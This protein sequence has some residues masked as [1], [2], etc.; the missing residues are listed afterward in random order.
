MKI[1]LRKL[2]RNFNLKNCDK[3]LSNTQKITFVFN[4]S[5]FLNSNFSVFCYYISL[6]S[7]NHG[8][9]QTKKINRLK[10][11]LAIW[12]KKEK[13]KK[14]L[15]YL[16][17]YLRFMEWIVIQIFFLNFNTPTHYLLKLYLTNTLRPKVNWIVNFIS[18][19]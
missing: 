2:L 16:C 18:N 11:I 8:T 9:M 19:R 12:L 4:N 10:K 3:L 15:L 1:N 6:P 13:K 14:N 17:T 7:I 5:L